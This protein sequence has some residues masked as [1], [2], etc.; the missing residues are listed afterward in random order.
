MKKTHIYLYVSFLIL[1]FGCEIS[2]SDSPDPQD[3]FV[4]YYGVDGS[5]IGVDLVYDPIGPGTIGSSLIILGSQVST[6]GERIDR[7]VV[8]RR[9]D[10]GGNEIATQVFDYRDQ[11]PEG[12]GGGEDEPGAILVEDEGFVI[13][14]TSSRDLGANN[15][16]S[17]IFIQ[18]LNEN[19]DPIRDLIIEVVDT[20]DNALEGF[21]LRGLDVVRTSDGSNDLI[22]TGSSNFEESGDPIADIS[23]IPDNE[24][25]IF[26]AR[27]NMETDS[28]LWR[29]TRGFEGDDEGIY[30]DEFEEDNFVIIGTSDKELSSQGRNVILLPINELASPNDGLASGFMIDGQEDFDDVATAVF[31]RPSGYVVT[32]ISSKAGADTRPFFINYTYTSAEAVSMEIG[33]EIDLGITDLENP[34]VVVPNPEGNG[35]GIAIGRNGNY[36]VVGEFLNYPDKNSE[37]LVSQLDQSGNEVG[38]SRRNY[39]L[40]AGSDVGEDIVVLPSGDIMILSTV[41]FG[42]GNTLISLMRLNQEGDIAQ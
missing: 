16:H 9:V 8:V 39:G 41:D 15:P 11:D 7:D 19:L 18:E 6:V 13:V 36:V 28:V 12:N 31:K 2:D 5:Q 21:N 33:K 3:T 35:Y 38:A 1:L 27:V 24:T 30:I 26:I 34:P 42:S 22:V 37:I 17:V 20:V 23:G 14:G 32:G 29:R 10:M 40:S 25:Q 4:K